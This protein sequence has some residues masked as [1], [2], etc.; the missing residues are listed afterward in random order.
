MYEHGL[1]KIM[2][3]LKTAPAAP[4]E[5]ATQVQ[6]AQYSKESRRYDE[7]NGKLFT[8]MLLATADCREGYASVAAQVVQ[9]YAPVG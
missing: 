3:G 4:K 1:G 8:R 9:A 2:S 7:K 6:K 5:D